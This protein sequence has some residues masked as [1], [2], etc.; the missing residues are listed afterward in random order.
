M[1]E[2]TCRLDTSGLTPAIQQFI[3]VETE[4]FQLI[5]TE[6]LQVGLPKQMSSGSG[7][8]QLIC[9]AEKSTAFQLSTITVRNKASV[10]IH[11]CD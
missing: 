10:F 9:R 11:H 8:V 3:A 6:L 1:C 4:F 2:L 7:A 5:R